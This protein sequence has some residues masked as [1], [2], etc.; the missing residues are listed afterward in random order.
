MTKRFD[1]AVIGGG[2]HGCGVAQAAAAGGY[3]VVVLEQTSLAAGTSSRSSKLIHGG[4]RYLESAQF[5]LVYESLA[6]RNRLL[7]NA[8]QLVKRQQFFI[9][10]YKYSRRP[11]WQIAMG[12]SLY[13]LMSG[14]RSESWFR[15]IAPQRWA[16]L[17]GINQRELKKVF[18]YWDA[19]T[20]DRELTRAVMYSAVKM[21]AQLH[22]P[23]RVNAAR[24]EADRFRVEYHLNGAEHTL[25]S[26][27]L[28]NAA[29]PWIPEVQ[30]R[31][32]PAV[33]PPA[34]DLVQG[35]HIVIEQ[36]APRAVYYVESLV[37]HRVV[38]IMPW[39]GKTLVGTTEHQYEGAPAE[40]APTE[41]EIAYLRDLV[42][43]YFPHF[44]DTLAETFAGLR[45][46]PRQPRTA[47]HRPRETVFFQNEKLPGYVALLGGKL[48][49]YRAVAEKTIGLLD[50][51][52]PPR[53]RIGDTRAL[54]MAPA[55]G[56]FAN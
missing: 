20:D 14:L 39:Y 33:E 30:K 31:I 1:I 15:R 7:R 11:P 17:D 19:Q 26:R 55:P 9:P 35:S 6:E 53:A 4:L 48:T 13:A 38:F 16:D 22:C 40:A 23:A 37:D 29:G 50:G 56:N 34:I 3:S 5:S 18:Q 52:L 27:C 47:F 24:L 8:P 2:I 46:L 45:V 28:I 42:R 43:H 41:K 36:P 10:V 32:A 12:L 25:E 51:F 44:D 21:G 49:G 54:K